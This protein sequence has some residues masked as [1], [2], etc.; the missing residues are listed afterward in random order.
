M[1]PSCPYGDVH[2]PTF[3]RLI[4]VHPYL[5]NISRAVKYMNVLVISCVYICIKKKEKGKYI[6]ISYESFVGMDVA[7]ED[8][9]D[10]RGEERVLHSFLH[11]R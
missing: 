10:T 3:I 8:D 7:G 6:Y 4:L 5:V 11:P 2:R 9:V 1:I